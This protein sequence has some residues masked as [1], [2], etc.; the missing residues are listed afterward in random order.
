MQMRIILL[1]L[2]ISDNTLGLQSDVEMVIGL[3]VLSYKPVY[4][5]GRHK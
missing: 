5:K 4:V 3:Q 2:Q 1:A